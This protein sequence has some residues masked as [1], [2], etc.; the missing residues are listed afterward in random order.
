MNYSAGEYGLAIAACS[1]DDTTLVISDAQGNWRCSDDAEGSNP[2]VLWP[3]A[4]SGTYDV[5]VGRFRAGEGD[6]TLV[7][8]ENR[9]P[10]C[11]E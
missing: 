10:Y 3:N 11:G 5:W 1:S 2:V 9:G 6:A 8:S 4:P 7:V